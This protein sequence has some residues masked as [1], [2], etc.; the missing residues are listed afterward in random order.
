MNARSLSGI[1]D[2]TSNGDVALTMNA[3]SM[4][5]INDTFGGGGDVFQAGNPNTF[6][7]TNTFNTNRPT[8]SLATTPGSTD[9]ITKTDGEA[10][11]TNNT[12]D[13]LLA[14]GTEASPQTFTEFNKFDKLTKFGVVR[15]QLVAD[16]TTTNPTDY[17]FITKTD[18][19]ALYGSITNNAQ[20]DGGVTREEPQT[21]TE[22][23][24]FNIRPFS[25]I[26]PNPPFPIPANEALDGDFIMKRDGDDLYLSRTTS[27]VAF[28]N[29][30]NEF[31][32]GGLTANSF[33][34]RPTTALTNTITS[35]M[36]IT[37]DDAENRLS[38]IT[39]GEVSSSGL[40]GTAVQ[41]GELL[42]FINATGNYPRFVIQ[43]A[44]DAN[45][46]VQLGRHGS[47]G[48]GYLR[49]ANNGSSANGI[50]LLGNG[51]SYF[52]GG[53][54]KVAPAS[55]SHGTAKFLVGGGPVVINSYCYANAFVNTSDDRI[56]ENKKLIINATETLLKLTPQIY[57]KY[58]DMDLSGNTRV[59]SGL[60]AQEIYYNAP[61][62][63]H[64]VEVG[65]TTDASGNEITPT[66]D[67]MDLSGVDIGSDPDY[68]SHGWGKNH[69]ASLNYSGLIA[70]LIKSNQELHQ[71]ISILETKINN[72]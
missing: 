1:N 33:D 60:I 10:L 13:A 42:Q 63:R 2:V 22:F 57:D 14:G 65:L 9:F 50:F 32:T 8:S 5:G 4:S 53:Q 24:K 68:G 61:E 48:N 30:A 69:S 55:T 44:N 58:D 66:P 49:C 39:T 29:S 36:F 23:N 62:L 72:M 25:D 40:R 28:L 31:A 54:L 27:G 19:D 67:E 6:T 64:L 46:S 41:D 35:Q 15:P 38:S 52:S 12:G 34:P 71:R 56:K 3:R 47:S 26:I 17:E 45:V 20:L 51:N 21:F 16:G 11:F 70:Y 59:E 7:G 18:G 37:K 43:G